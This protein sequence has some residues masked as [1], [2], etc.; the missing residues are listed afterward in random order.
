MRKRE[1]PE[2]EQEPLGVLLLPGKL[3][4]ID[5]QAHARDLLSIPRM[6]ALE[7]P[8]LR[9]PGTLR[10]LSSVRQAA[11]LR[12]PGRPRLLVLYHPE[13]FPLARAV[14][15][16]EEE[17]ELWYFPPG[18]AA[19]SGQGPALE[20][21]LLDFDG[22]ARDRAQR[23]IEPEDLEAGTGDLRDRLRE[24]GIISPY[25]FVPGARTRR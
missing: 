24:L 25:A 13:Q 4:E 15:V 5:R 10:E 7:P 8:R 12:F 18:H 9:L 22:L 20:E 14:C 19:L 16:R 17:T 11:R 23:V 21:R 2:Q 1:E 3:E 6:V